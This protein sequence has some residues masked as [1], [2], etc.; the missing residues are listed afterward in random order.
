MTRETVYLGISTT[1]IFLVCLLY[2]GNN[3]PLIPWNGDDWNNFICNKSLFPTLRDWNPSRVL[4]E[5]LSPL[6]GLISAYIITPLCGDYITAFTI[7]HTLIY[8]AAISTFSLVVY[9]TF[10]SIFNTSFLALAAQLFFFCLTWYFFKNS[11]Q[12]IF[13]FYT[14]L[15]TISLCYTLPTLLAAGL[16]CWLITRACGAALPKGKSILVA[17]IYFS[18][19]SITT[20][21]VLPATCAGLIFVALLISRRYK[22]YSHLAIL[23]IAILLLWT[24]ALVFDFYGARYADFQGNN[25]SIKDAANAFYALF[26]QGRQ[27]MHI[28]LIGSILL[29]ALLLSLR[30]WHKTMTKQDCRVALALFL[31][32]GSALLC[33][34]AFILIS[35]K[36]A[37]LCGN[38]HFS[39][40]FYILLFLAQ[41]LCLAYLAI[42]CALFRNLIPLLLIGMCIA[43]TAEE[44]SWYIPP[45]VEQQAIVRQWIHDIRAAEAAGQKQ[46]TIAVPRTEWPHPKEYFGERL[47][48][49]LY[50]HG[51]TQ[52]KMTILLRTIHQEK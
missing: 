32:V 49:V 16:T 1:S 20:A 38:I 12:N 33:G 43:C 45:T 41:T 6:V 19:F 36:S 23:C 18:L 5:F 52:Q 4:P 14:P 3:A 34:L 47:A 24:I 22:Q 10:L 48:R 39:S 51:I 26:T 30:A 25:A 44:K 15:I 29:T 11:A 13:L 35:T 50:Y 2:F 31:L 46:V 8:S 7:T 28:L 21:S 9:R 27:D 42:R 37:L 17:T 40:G